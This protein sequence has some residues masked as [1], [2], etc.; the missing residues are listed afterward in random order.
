ML[1]I[2]AGVA[3]IPSV[4]M[5][6]GSVDFP[7]ESKPA[8]GLFLLSRG[9]GDVPTRSCLDGYPP[10]PASELNPAAARGKDSDSNGHAGWFGFAAASWLPD[11]CSHPCFKWGEKSS[12]APGQEQQGKDA[13]VALPQSISQDCLPG[14]AEPGF[15]AQF[16]ERK[17]LS[18][19]PA[20]LIP[21]LQL[22]QHLPSGIQE[23]K[24]AGGLAGRASW[25]CD[26]MKSHFPPVTQQATLS[27]WMRN[28]G[29]APHRQLPPCPRPSVHAAPRLPSCIPARG[30]MR[31][32]PD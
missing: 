16:W 31:L 21:R 5:I 15:S 8:K 30:D 19:S 3:T 14:R 2:S 28:A 13:L 27:S 10:L 7:A 18:R 17:G 12:T 32:P 22:P 1:F 29:E 11:G 6:K 4:E 26:W 25:R 9:G 20:V 24:A 23:R